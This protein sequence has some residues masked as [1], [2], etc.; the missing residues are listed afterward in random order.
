VALNL[1]SY[2]EE[3]SI[4]LPKF[5]L[6]RWISLSQTDGNFV[7]LYEHGPKILSK[8]FVLGI[9]NR[10]PQTVEKTR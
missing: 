3:I 9:I 7:P 8:P 4:D 5:F 2:L 1:R 6:H 10:L